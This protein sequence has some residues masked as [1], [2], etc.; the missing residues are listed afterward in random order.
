M[1]PMKEWE[2]GRVPS[3]GEEAA[4]CNNTG[5]I[6]WVSIL[7]G[8]MKKSEHFFL[9]T[10]QTENWLGVVRIFHSKKLSNFAQTTRC[11]PTLL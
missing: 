3:R 5:L 1:G 11:T 10:P 4:G 8:G 7:I 9:Q 2:Y 6:T